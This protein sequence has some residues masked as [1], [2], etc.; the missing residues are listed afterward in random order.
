MTKPEINTQLRFS[1]SSTA[2]PAN[3][4]TRRR[5]E[6]I[7]ATFKPKSVDINALIFD[8]DGTLANTMHLHWNAWQKV[9]KKHNFSFSKNEFFEMGGTPTRD[10]LR[11]ILKNNLQCYDIE[12]IAKDKETA[13]LDQINEIK[14]IDP[15]VEL[16]R[17]FFKQKPMA[18]ATGTTQKVA[19]L[20][21]D[22]LGI[23]EMFD[24]IITSQDVVK[25]KPDPEIFLEA[26]RRLH[27]DHRNCAVFE[28][29]KRV[30][31][32][33]KLAGMISIDVRDFLTEFYKNQNTASL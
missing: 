23:L 11:K 17:A 31:E 15:V 30:L 12:S 24:L 19:R 18:V 20:V 5:F 32:Q 8:L 2:C 7:L 6:N 26:S 3:S 16:A 13:Y 28:D 14:P 33:I 27:V 25:Q 9:M 10:I 1:G 29:S 4:F 21:L 22:H